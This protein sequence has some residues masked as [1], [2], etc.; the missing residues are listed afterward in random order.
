MST[1]QPKNNQS[2]YT[3]TLFG[4]QYYFND[5]E[6]SVYGDLNNYLGTLRGRDKDIKNI[7]SA[8]DNLMTGIKDGA[9]TFQGGKFYDSQGR[10]KNNLYYDEEGNPRTSRRDR[11]D[12]YGIAANYIYS[13]MGKSKAISKDTPETVEWNP[14]LYTEE[15]NKRL[16]NSST[17]DY[18]S[19]I[20]ADTQDTGTSNRARILSDVIRSINFNNKFPG[21]SDD[22]YTRQNEYI[23]QALESL[24]DGNVTDQ[25]YLILSR[26]LPG[27]DIN[28]MFSSTQS[29]QEIQE[30]QKQIELDNAAQEFL[31]WKQSVYP[32]YEGN[33]RVPLSDPLYSTYDQSQISQLQSG[34]NNSSL[35]D[36]YKTLSLSLFSDDP[37][38][39]NKS[40]IVGNIFGNTTTRFSNAYG[41]LQI[42]NTLKNKNGLI[43]VDENNPYI[44]YIP[45]LTSTKDRGAIYTWNSS[46]NTIQKV[47]RDSIPYL[48][49][50]MVDEF[51]S[52][53]NKNSQWWLNYLQS[54]RNGGIIKAQRGIALPEYNGPYEV[55][56]DMDN[57]VNPMDYGDPVRIQG[58]GNTNFT[59]T[60]QRY[61]T[62]DEITNIHNSKVYNQF[63]EAL[64]DD[65]GLTDIGEKYL[66]W[67]DQ[68]MPN[69]ELKF[70]SNG[71]LK[72]PYK[73]IKALSERINMLRTDGKYGS[74]YNIGRP[75][76]DRY[77][78]VNTE[79]NKVY[80][81]P[82]SISDYDI[83]QD[84]E[85]SINNGLEYRDYEI[86]SKQVTPKTDSEVNRSGT[87]VYPTQGKTKNQS[88]WNKAGNFGI[89]S[90]PLISEAGRMAYSIRTNN[91]IADTIE[92]SLKPSLK[93]TYERYSPVT[94][95]FGEI[96]FRN[97]QAAN[98]RRQ[99]SRPFTSDAQLQ[100][101]SQM[102]ANRQARDLEYQ[103]FLADDREIRRT[104]QE[105]LARQEDN[106]ARRSEV[107]NYNRD[108]FNK[109]NREK[110]ALEASRLNK[111][112]ESVDKFW[113]NSTNWL[114]NRLTQRRQGLQNLNQSSIQDRYSTYLQQYNRDWKRKNPNAT[115][116]D[117]LSDPTYIDTVKKMRNRLQYE[118]NST[119]LNPYRYTYTIPQDYDDILRNTPIS[120]KYGGVLTQKSINL[121]NKIIKNESNT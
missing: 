81:D 104:R 15:I 116:A 8:V 28:K 22:L 35:S 74:A 40:S 89:E 83:S 65:K 9:V 77:Y 102:E 76:S 48:Q 26:L 47:S 97:N 18:Q 16:F 107:A 73:D 85:S 43:Q 121:I 78:Y 108:Q 98:L 66:K 105:A 24:K 62:Q 103:G 20:K 45:Y 42:L 29:P 25:D 56:F 5:L 60:P 117:M 38:Y 32:T 2:E 19:F 49:K 30:E 36:L 12:Y 93:S 1:Q 63:G 23:N 72:E 115:E 39:F 11:K 67:Y 71:V 101:A 13:K 58:R 37:W 3:Y 112:W 50:Q 59:Y 69:E 27:L 87:S 64:I 51:K 100:L 53:K 86:S 61:L 109:V 7:R 57:M 17:P 82:E 6:K 31:E 90:L 118:L 68:Q 21:Q 94:G 70:Y 95:A 110:A 99:A 54:N 96:S 14:T 34:L 111:N 52:K 44:Y 84:Y 75:Y 113:Q 4:D 10:Y 80:V 88:F 119:I 33:V 106:M 120:A 41:I 92:K 114:Q 55:K 79:G 46:N 91:K